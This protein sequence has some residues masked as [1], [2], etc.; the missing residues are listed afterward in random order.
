MNDIE[1]FLKSFVAENPLQ[2]IGLNIQLKKTIDKLA[3]KSK[4]W[5]VFKR[6]IEEGF[7]DQKQKS[8]AE[9]SYHPDNILALCYALDIH[10]MQEL[11]FWCDSVKH[12]K[13]ERVLNILIPKFNVD[14]S[15]KPKIP[16]KKLLELLDHKS[17]QKEEDCSIR[18]RDSY[19][20][21]LKY[22]ETERLLKI[23]F[24]LSRKYIID[25]RD[26]DDFAFTIPTFLG[27]CGAGNLTCGYCEVNIYDSVGE[28]LGAHALN[29]AISLK[30]GKYRRSYLDIKANKIRSPERAKEYKMRFLLI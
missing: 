3:K 5:T 11:S 26:C 12:M 24:N 13:F 22:S 2:Q 10:S 8:L 6:L 27:R 18:I 23:H 21:V 20:H 7:W 28:K 9:N 25:S 30:D 19:Y 15:K 14:L 4:G 1:E 29:F 17:I 16:A